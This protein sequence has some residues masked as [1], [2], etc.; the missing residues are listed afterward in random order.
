LCKAHPQPDLTVIRSESLIYEKP[1]LD[2]GLWTLDFG[3]ALVM[4]NYTEKDGRLIFKVR[5]VPRSSRNEIVGEHDGALR[6]KLTA[7]PV[8]GAANTAL[9][10]I[11]ARAFK[12]SPAAVEIISGQ[13]SRMKTVGIVG[14]GVPNFQRL[15]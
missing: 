7:P 11:L 1:T 10:R 5:V 9:V 8:E 3:L 13:T 12:V 6:V 14:V 15:L 4:I 2:F